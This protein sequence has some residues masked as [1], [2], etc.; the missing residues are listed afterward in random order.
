MSAACNV[1]NIAIIKAVLLRDESHGRFL[2]MVQNVAE[3]EYVVAVYQFMRLRGYP[4]NKISILTTY[5]GQK[6]LIRDVIEQ[7]CAAHPAFG[8]PQTV[9]FLYPASM[10]K[11]WP[12]SAQMVYY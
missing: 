9:L 10:V 8:R 11:S 4:A 2:A 6:A 1:A 3:A 5:N 12:G 7:R